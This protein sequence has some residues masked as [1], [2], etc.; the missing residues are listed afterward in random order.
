MDQTKAL[1]QL[2]EAA[3]L[4]SML[5]TL[6]APGMIEKMA[7]SNSWSGLRITLRNV[8][9]AI[10]ASHDG[11]AEQVVALARAGF[12]SAATPAQVTTIVTADPETSKPAAA[13]RANAMPQQNGANPMKIERRD[14]RTQLERFIER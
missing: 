6:T 11:L 3:D 9:D 2:I 10:L 13:V 14:L 12:E 5:E 7:A 1:H 8:R 4:V